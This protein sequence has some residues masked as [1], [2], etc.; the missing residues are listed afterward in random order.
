[1]LIV[2]A[3]Q[4][5]LSPLRVNAMSAYVMHKFPNVIKT[6]SRRQKADCVMFAA[7]ASGSKWSLTLGNDQYGRDLIENGIT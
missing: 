7:I 3:L 1:M 4:E 6:S 5:T 2:I